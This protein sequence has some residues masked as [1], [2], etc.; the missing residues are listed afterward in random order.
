MNIDPRLS[1][2][3]NRL[4]GVE[5]VVAVASGKGGVGKSS[6]SACLALLMAKAGKRVGL[7]DLDF[8]GPS[9][10]I[11]LGAGDAF[12][13]ED[14]GI[15]PPEIAGVRLMTPAYYAGTS[16]VP[17]RGTDVSSALLELIAI[18]RWDELDLLVLDMPPGVGDATLD[19]IRHLPRAEYLVV[20]TPSL[21]S[22]ETVARLEGL[23][24]RC[25][26]PILGTV[27]NRVTEGAPG[28]D[29]ITTWD[30]R[31]DPS[32]EAAIGAPERLL[33][34]QFSEDLQRAITGL[35]LLTGRSKEMHACV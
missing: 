33:A 17:F 26:R 27:R 14:R 20:T 13:E 4:K 29:A 35:G 18:T 19:L 16:P 31:F 8:H 11:L 7:F 28:P 1:A 15:V 23:L 24:L 5:R 10:H 3:E 6:V 22:H 12:P 9:A 25:Q 32:Y 2:I 21:L 30:V 34:T